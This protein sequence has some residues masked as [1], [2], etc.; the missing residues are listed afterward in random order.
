ML[1]TS[2]KIVEKDY[3][4]IE[5]SDNNISVIN[6]STLRHNC[7][8]ALCASEKENRG[9]KYFPIYSAEEL[10]IS[11]INII[12]NYALG[13][14]WKDGHNTGIYEFDYLKKFDNSKST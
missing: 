14:T 6:L 8:C 12:G 4:K 3:L 1:P 11:N 10:T 9:D 2:I 5:W 13:I 7:P